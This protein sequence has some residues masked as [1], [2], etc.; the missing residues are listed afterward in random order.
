MFPWGSFDFWNLFV[1]SCK[2]Q[3]S[4]FLQ[5]RSRECCLQTLCFRFNIT[6]QIL[7]V[8]L[9][10]SAVLSCVC[11]RVCV[12]H[13][14]TVGVVEW[15]RQLI[16]LVVNKLL[17]G[18][19]SSRGHALTHTVDEVCTEKNRCMSNT[20]DYGKNA[21]TEIKCKSC[22]HWFPFWFWCV[23]FGLVLALFC[24]GAQWKYNYF[25]SI[26]NENN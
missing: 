15:V 23:A 18:V 19:I 3:R 4:S 5:N 17:P 11:V 8:W 14:L 20:E 2:G 13:V 12:S 21:I 24:T 9:M 22:C 6:T 16:L 1:F 25:I 7:L 26:T 10:I